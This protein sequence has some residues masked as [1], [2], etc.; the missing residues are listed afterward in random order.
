MDDSFAIVFA[1]LMFPVMIAIYGFIFYCLVRILNK[2]GFSG[3]WS[4]MF[5]LWPVGL[6]MFAFSDWPALR[7]RKNAGGDA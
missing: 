1:L 2:A 6:A 4:L 7:T 5:F 3:W